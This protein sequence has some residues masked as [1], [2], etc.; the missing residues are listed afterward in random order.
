M[1]QLPKP[2]ARYHHFK[3]AYSAIAT[4]SSGLIVVTVAFAA[5][6]EA[7][8]HKYTFAWGLGLL[9][10]SVIFQILILLANI[11]SSGHDW[12]FRASGETAEEENEFAQFWG[13]TAGLM[14]VISILMTAIGFGCMWYFVVHNLA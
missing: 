8:T 6:L 10:S 2:A 1:E 14:L 13:K 3:E 11:I 7:T 9:C 5:N 4:L 12:N